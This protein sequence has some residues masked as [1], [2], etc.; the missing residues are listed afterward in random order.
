M[1]HSFVHLFLWAYNVLPCVIA[2]NQHDGFLF[3]RRALQEYILEIAQDSTTG[4][5]RDKPGKRCDAYHT[6]YNLSGL[7]LCQYRVHLD[8]NTRAAMWQAWRPLPEASNL[9][10]DASGNIDSWRRACYMGMMSWT[11]D[12]KQTL[13]L[14]APSNRLNITHP[15]F[16]VPFLTAK[17]IL[18]WAYAQEVPV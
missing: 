13:V 4:G 11:I 5:L 10:G 7:S 8:A 16:N 17:G 1:G 3:D 6:C 12:P 18:D 2:A 9:N 14:G 15:I